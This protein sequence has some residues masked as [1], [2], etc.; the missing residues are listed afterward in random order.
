MI[1]FSEI[2][3]KKCVKQR[4]PHTTAEMRPD[5][6]ARPSQQQQ[7]SFCYEFFS[8]RVY[9]NQVVRVVHIPSTKMYVEIRFGIGAISKPMFVTL[10]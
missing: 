7:L 2:T 5:N 10:G 3:E 4:Y 9:T 8:Y 1:I 6:I